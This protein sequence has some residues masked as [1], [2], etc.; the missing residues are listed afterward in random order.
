MVNKID[1]SENLDA[2]FE[3]MSTQN[4]IRL[5]ESPSTLYQ[6]NAIE[7][8]AKRLAEDLTL[9]EKLFQ[10][11]IEPKNQK[12]RVVGTVSV[13]HIAIGNLLEY[14]DIQTEKRIQ[15][16]LQDWPEPDRTDLQWYLEGK[17]IM[18]LRN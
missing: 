12:N 11:I 8:L 2:Q 3:Q 1:N 14:G 18:S 17:G 6:A 4:L 9:T 7:E 15:V 5:L 13:A 10:V 16:L